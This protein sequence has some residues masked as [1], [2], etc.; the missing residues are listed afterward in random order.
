MLKLHVKW[1]QSERKDMPAKR[2]RIIIDTNLWISFLITSDYSKLDS[3]LINQRVDL[4]FSKELLTEFIEVANRPKL[5][6]YFKSSDIEDLLILLENRM[7]LV[8]VRCKIKICR[9]PKDN[10]LLELAKD[11][12]A[13]FLITGDKDLLELKNLGKTKIMTIAQFLS[14]GLH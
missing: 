10:F 9:D 7:E 4:L 5:K 3:L 8:E 13:D 14:T 12:K 11:G 6:K 2:K 1:K